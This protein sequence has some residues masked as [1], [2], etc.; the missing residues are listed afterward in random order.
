MIRSKEYLSLAKCQD[1][2]AASLPAAALLLL[3]V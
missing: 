2:A 1:A 3:P